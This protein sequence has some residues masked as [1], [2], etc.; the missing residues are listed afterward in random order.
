MIF[1]NVVVGEE[2]TK[3]VLVI[4]YTVTLIVKLVN[5]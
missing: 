2:H 1:V 4:A 3:K 5:V